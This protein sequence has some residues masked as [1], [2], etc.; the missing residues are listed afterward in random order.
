MKLS[1]ESL[2]REINQLKNEIDLL[3]KDNYILQ[4]ALSTNKKTPEDCQTGNWCKCC[5]Y[6][7]EFPTKS[8][9]FSVCGYG[10]RCSHFSQKI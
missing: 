5:M 6:E 10:V 8:G 7:L 4:M 3:E 1:K 2:L 9:V